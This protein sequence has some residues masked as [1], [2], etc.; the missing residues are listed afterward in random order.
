MLSNILTK[1]YINGGMK[2]FE[3]ESTANLQTA[4]SRSL[5][6]TI[7]VEIVKA[8]NLNDKDKILWQVHVEDNEMKIRV[9]KKE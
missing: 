9:T 4:H 2:L 3:L 1:K 8:L 5:R 6:T 7:P